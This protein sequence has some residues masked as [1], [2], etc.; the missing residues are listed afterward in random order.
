MNHLEEL[1]DIPIFSLEK[2][3]KKV[4]F[5]RI[6][7]KL[8]RNHYEKCDNY[9]RVLD[10]LGFNTSLDHVLEDI[11]YIPARLFK[12][13]RLSSIDDDKVVKTLIS[14]G[15]TGQSRST[16]VLN[17]ENSLNQI[18]VLTKT[19]SSLSGKKRLPMLVVDS[20]SVIKDRD[21]FSARGAGI[22]GFSMLATKVEYALNEEM[23]LDIRLVQQ[24]AEK[25]SGQSVLIFGFTY[26]IWE[27]FC[28][29]LIESKGLLNLDQAILIH[30]GGWK[31]MIDSAVDNKK[32]KNT[33]NEVIG[34]K[35]VHDYYGM[36]E[37]TG[38]IYLECEKG[39]LHTSIYSD[40]I[41]R[42][43]NF[44]ICD[45]NE[46]GIIQ[47]MSLLPTSYPGHCILTEDLGM[48]HG[49]DNCSCGR[50]GKYFSVIGRIKSAEVRGCSDTFSK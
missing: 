22:L 16:I 33:V 11:P 18:K 38:S 28:K 39:Y 8:V 29:P 20:P 19:I 32:F 45:T 41:I 17:K 48:L 4:L 14:S 24:F 21:K 13:H 6:I 2:S 49:E 37:Q 35:Q 44:S 3:K 31:K 43:N 1:Q 42:K 40:V 26:M 5:T 27:Y 25:Y 7:N 30:G 9:K 15:T 34:V 12:Q 50:K 10:I 46:P 36:V 47:V 23:E